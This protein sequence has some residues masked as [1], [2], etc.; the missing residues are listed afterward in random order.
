MSKQPKTYIN[1]D[2]DVRDA[3][4]LTQPGTGRTFRNAWQ[5]NGDVIEVDMAAAR[6]I[7]KENLRRKR[8][9]K[10]DALDAKWFRAAEAGDTAAQSAVAA[11]KQALRDVTEA[12][13]LQTAGSPEELLKLEE[14]LV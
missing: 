13:A 9:P 5:F 14:T 6:E 11:K 1:I 10:L 12:A 7:T 8:Q 2:G 3:A 4:S